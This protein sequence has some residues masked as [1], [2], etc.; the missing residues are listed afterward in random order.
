MNSDNIYKICNDLG[1]DHKDIDK[2]LSTKNDKATE[3][4]VG[5][6][7]AGSK[8][9]TTCPKELYKSG[10][11][12]GTVGPTEIYKAGTRYGTISTDDF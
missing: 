6:Y 12:Y 4:S 9:G 7:K 8:Y 10:S 11:W 2:I 5:V 1:L 3:Y